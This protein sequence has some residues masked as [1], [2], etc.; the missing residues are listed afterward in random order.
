M[1]RKINNIIFDTEASIYVGCFHYNKNNLEVEL[2]ELYKEKCENF[3]FPKSI[4]DS[5]ITGLCFGYPIESTVD[6]ING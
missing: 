6:I 1:R 3:F 4:V 5:I 2:T